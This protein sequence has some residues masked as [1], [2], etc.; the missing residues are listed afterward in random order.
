MRG[1]QLYWRYLI[2]LFKS[3]IQYPMS[4][5]MLFGASFLSSAVELVGIIALFARFETLAGWTLPEVAMMYGIIKMSLALGEG[6]GRAFDQFA[7][8]VKSGDFDIVLLRPRSTALQV[9]GQEVQLVRLGSFLQAALVLGWAMNHLNLTLAPD[10]V[11]LAAFAVIGG[12]CLFYGLFVLQA[13]MT[14][15]TTETIEMMNILTYGGCDLGQYPIS[16]Y[17]PWFRS[18]F[19][20]V[21]PIGCITYFPLH[22]IAGKPE[23]LFGA[24]HWIGWIAPLAGIIFFLVALSIWNIGVRHYRSTGS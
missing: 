14:F 12:A 16:I 20:F 10:R 6:L 18:F 21:V 24:P 1:L 9:A 5:L 23:M 4:F 3:K 19:I 2:I 17:K 15:W 22:A 8:Q 11:V 7:A 13:T